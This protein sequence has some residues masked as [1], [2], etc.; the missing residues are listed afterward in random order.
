MSG[1]VSGFTAFAAA[2]ARP[3]MRTA[4]VL[5]RDFHAAQDLVQET[6]AKMF[7]TWQRPHGIDS[8]Q[9]YAHVVLV[10]TYVSQRRRKGFW[11]RPQAIIADAPTEPDDPALRVALAVAL[12]Q[13][14][15][16]D[17]AVLVL[18][19]MRDRSVEEV[20]ADL[21]KSPAAVRTQA[22]RA[23]ERLRQSLGGDALNDLARR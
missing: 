22:K 4:V 2:Q 8:P 9:A 3:L 21:G 23:L 6:L 17:R 1:D 20:A 18:R 12:A 13:L 16:A 11:E 15:P 19:Y 10:R 14:S 5:T 7:E